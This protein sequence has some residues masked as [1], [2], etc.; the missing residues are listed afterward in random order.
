MST[1]CRS[2]HGNARQDSP[3]IPKR[4]CTRSSYRQKRV[5]PGTLPEWVASF[6][7]IHAPHAYSFVSHSHRPLLPPF[8]LLLPFSTWLASSSMPLRGVA[9]NIRNKLHRRHSVFFHPQP[10]QPSKSIPTSPPSASH[11]SG[12]HPSKKPKKQYPPSADT[13]LHGIGEYLFVDELGRGKFSKVVLAQH[14]HTGERFAIKVST[15]MSIRWR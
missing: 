2:G 7:C 10:T 3:H 13:L 9:D 15:Y 5:L 12:H 4:D 14:Y 6:P 11:R 1:V 8:L